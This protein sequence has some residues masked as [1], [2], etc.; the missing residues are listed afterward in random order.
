[1]PI[2]ARLADPHPVEKP[3]DGIRPR[4]HRLGIAGK[5]IRFAMA[6]QVGGE[7]VA[8]GEDQIV[9]EQRR[10]WRVMQHQHRTPVQ[11]ARRADQHAVDVVGRGAAW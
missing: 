10:A 2:D 11:L 6:R 7:G 1:M 9:V 3:L 5:R 8:E 4:L